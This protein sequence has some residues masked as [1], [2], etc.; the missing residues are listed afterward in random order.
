[1]IL[2]AHQP[3]YLP[4][5]RLF[6]KIAAADLFCI[7]DIVQ[8]EAKAFENRNLVKTQA[9]PLMLTVPVQSK[10]HFN[11]TGGTIGVMPGNWQRKHIRSI[12]L[13]YKAA[14]FYKDYADKLFGILNREYERLAD[15]NREVLGFF[16]TTLGIRTPVVVASDHAFKGEKSALVL[17]MC[18][19]LEAT[20][21]LFGANGRQYADV[22]TFRAAGV[23]PL[24]QE[25]TPQEYPQLHGP[26]VP[27][28]SA[29]D[30]LMNVGGDDAR[31]RIMSSQSFS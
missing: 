1:M 3:Q 8:F 4:G 6:G 19:T 12:E 13:A 28:M 27:N 24:F 30:L 9:G 25:F 26:F 11:S 22:D 5:L 15:L 16:L 21:Y 18:R 14:P 17:D 10:D 29:L 31:Q 7:F 20:E 23:E 2:T